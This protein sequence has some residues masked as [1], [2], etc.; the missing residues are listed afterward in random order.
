MVSRHSESREYTR[1]HSQIDRAPYAGYDVAHLGQKVDT[2]SGL[3]CVV[4]G[5][6]H[7]A[8]DQ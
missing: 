4:E 1:K 3:I 7:E 6:V 8:G 2:D 5:V